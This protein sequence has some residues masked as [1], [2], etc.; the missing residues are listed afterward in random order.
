MAAPIAVLLWLWISM[1]VILIGAE[2]NGEIEHQTDRDTTTGKDR[3]MGQRGA[4]MADTRGEA[5]D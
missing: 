2:I 4:E 1:I 5:T 3:P